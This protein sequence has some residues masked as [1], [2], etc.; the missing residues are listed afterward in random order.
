[1]PYI[2]ITEIGGFKP[3]KI[4]PD[5]KAVVWKKMYE[6]SPVKYVDKVPKEK[7]KKEEPVD[8]PSAEDESS[9]EK[10]SD[11]S[12]DA[13]SDDYLNRNAKVVIKNV[14]EDDLSAETV[15]KLI[16]IESDNKNRPS[17]LGALDDK[18]E[19]VD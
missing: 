8:E 19:E 13:M 2:A 1:M 15:E 5:E 6:K 18:L 11:S 17:V 10:S 9:D 16:E 12:S 7:S 3:G 4:V 14:G